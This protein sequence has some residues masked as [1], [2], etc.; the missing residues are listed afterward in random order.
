MNHTLKHYFTLFSSLVGAFEQDHMLDYP[1]FTPSRM[2]TPDITA[3]GIPVRSATPVVRSGTPHLPSEDSSN[4]SKNSLNINISHLQHDR[5]LRP[6]EREEETQQVVHVLL[7]HISNL[8]N[9]YSFYSGLGHLGTADN[10]FVMTRLQFWRFL[11]DCRIHDQ[12]VTLIEMDRFIDANKQLLEIHD[13]QQDVL[14]RDF[15]NAIVTISYHVFKDQHSGCMPVLPWCVSKFICENILPDSCDVKGSLFADPARAVEALKYLPKSLDI[16]QLWCSLNHAP[17][18]EPTFKARQ[19]L[20]ML[21]DYRLLNDN[22]SSKE[23]LR[24]LASDDPHLAGDDFCNMELEM[25]FLDFFEALIECAA[26]FVTEAVM[27]DP[28]TPK[29]S[30][31][32]SSRSQSAR[33]FTP[34]TSKPGDD[35]PDEGTTCFKTVHSLKLGSH[36]NGSG[37][38]GQ[39]MKFHTNPVNQ[40]HRRKQ[41]L[42]FSSVPSPFYRV[43]MEF[44]ASVFTSISIASMIQA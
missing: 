36:Y 23:V 35:T 27:K 24:I 13:P 3:S 10:T 4:G 32:T 41:T 22:L 42:P 15:L 31:E 5:E 19:F 2:T 40:R 28:G 25:T 6:N 43:C 44:H 16:F 39:S 29:A 18:H 33:S 20:F 12:D 7:R 17:P 14:M 30:S 34:V 26:V 9:I 38:R 37:D 8:K 1:D 11:K 21:T